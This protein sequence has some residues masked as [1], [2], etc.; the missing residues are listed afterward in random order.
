MV[1]VLQVL[2]PLGE[3]LQPVLEASDTDLLQKH[4]ATGN[5]DVHKRAYLLAGANQLDV[6]QTVGKQPRGAGQ[7]GKVEDGHLLD[8]DVGREHRRGLDLELLEVNQSVLKW[9]DLD[10]L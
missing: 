5:H 6:L 8:G 10:G 7:A 4:V 9:V 2:Q 1:G 3:D